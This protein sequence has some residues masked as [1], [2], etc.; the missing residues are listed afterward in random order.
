MKFNEVY[1]NNCTNIEAA[2]ASVVLCHS[3]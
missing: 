1:S 3:G 2:T